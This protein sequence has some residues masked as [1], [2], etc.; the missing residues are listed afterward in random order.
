MGVIWAATHLASGERVALKLLRPSTT[1][2]ASTPPAPRP[3]SARGGARSI[4]RTCVDPRRAGA[5]RRDAV[6]RHGAAR[7]RVAPRQ[8]RCERRRSR[9]PSCRASCCR[10]SRR[11]APRTPRASSTATSSPTTSSCAD[12]RR[13]RRATRAKVL[14]FG[15]AKLRARRA[16]GPAAHRRPARC[17]ARRTTCRPSRSCGERDVDHRAD[18]YALGVILYECLTSVRPT[19]AENMGKV[20]KRI[21]TGAIRPI[22]EIAPA[23]PADVAAM[24]DRMLSPDRAQRPANLRE[25][26]AL[27]AR[28]AAVAPPPVRAPGGAP[29]ATRSCPAPAPATRPRSTP[30]S[31]DRSR[32]A[33]PIWTGRPRP[34]R[35]A[36][37]AS[38]Q[39]PPSSYSAVRAPRRSGR[40]GGAARRRGA[41]LAGDG[42]RPAALVERRSGRLAGEGR[43]ARSAQGSSSSPPAC[44]SPPEQA[45][46]CFAAPPRQRQER[47]AS[48]SSR[49]RRARRTTRRTAEQRGA[50]QLRVNRRCL[51]GKRPKPEVSVSSP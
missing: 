15:I 21:L 14:D 26:G 49:R 4:T 35:C 2:D 9:S 30:A 16:G 47:R 33:P 5:R 27:L 41:L 1:E 25:V 19:E 40:P 38:C 50:Q 11:S 29:G 17:S 36:Q 43:A 28:Y 6:P 24:I 46:R 22:G 42:R 51:E 8:A 31:A 37:A 44:S 48:S 45:C 23:L 3:G 39:R 7:G 10:S 18:I 34:R 20:M 32:P 12:A 13:R